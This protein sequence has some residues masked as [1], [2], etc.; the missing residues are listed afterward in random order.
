[1]PVTIY[2]NPQCS[3]SRQTLKLLEARGVKP[4]I[5]EYLKNPP[6][7]S[8]LRQ[9]LKLLGLKPRELLRKKEEEYK[10]SRLDKTDL[11]DAEII[12]AMVKYPR[13]IERPIVVCGN[14]A[15]LGRPPEDVLRIL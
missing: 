13:L 7:E 5:V 6:S 11:S 3:K 8:E 4:K 10:K 1:M 15:A 9:L 14:K 2:H 12:R